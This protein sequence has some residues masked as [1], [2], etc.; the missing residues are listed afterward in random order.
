M[1]ENQTKTKKELF[2]ERLRTK[3]PEQ[4]FDDEEMLYGRISDD[5]DEN[6]KSIA[7]YKE[8]ESKMSDLFNKDKRNARFLTDMAKGKDPWIGVIERMGIE[9][10]TEVMNDPAKQE[11]YAEANKK[12]LEKVAEE[13][14]LEEEYKANFAESMAL[15][16]KIQQERGLGDETIDAAYELIQ[17]IANEA[18]MGKFTQ[19]TVDMALKAITR[20]ADVSNARQ[21]G[22]ISGRNA[23]IEEQLRRKQSGDGLP[24]MTGANGTS[25]GSRENK[26]VFDLAGEAR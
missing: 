11:A 25:G 5:Y 26:S 10:I 2:M 23:K 22:A 16:E 14:K 18:I 20:D 9:G 6:E 4:N 17:K 1:A 15:L 13:D 12:Y 21:E 24:A 7:G 3:Y 8:R 19:E